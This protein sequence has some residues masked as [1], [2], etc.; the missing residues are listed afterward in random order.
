MH[1]Y[2]LIIFNIIIKTAIVKT[3]LHIS[4]VDIYIKAH[5]NTAFLPIISS[6]IGHKLF[7]IENIFRLI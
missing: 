2:K 1:F 5:V 6:T 3:M 7:T 4:H